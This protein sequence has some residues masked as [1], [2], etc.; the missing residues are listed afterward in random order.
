M[1]K[2]AV[3]VHKATKEAETEKAAKATPERGS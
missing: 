1:N 2:V 3:T